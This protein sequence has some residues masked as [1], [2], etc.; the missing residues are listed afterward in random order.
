[1]TAT[2]K[3]IAKNRTS[4]ISTVDTKAEVARGTLVSMGA[5][6]AVV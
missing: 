6:G 2:I 4:V 5:A 1:M 3:S